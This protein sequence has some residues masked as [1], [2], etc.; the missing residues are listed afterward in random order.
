MLSVAVAIATYNRP[1]QLD[2][3]L[4]AWEQSNL[5]PDQ[6][7]VVDASADAA[8]RASAVAGALPGRFAA[9]R[10]AY[11]SAATPSTTAQRNQ[12]V[13]ALGTDLVV[14]A[15]DDTM[16]DPQ[17]LER[18]V[19]VFAADRRGRVGGVGGKTDRRGQGLKAWA[20][21]R[22]VRPLVRVVGQRYYA[23]RRVAFPEEAAPPPLPASIPV[24][25]MKLLNGCNMA[26]RTELVRAERF[27]ES[28]RGYAYGE[29][30]D[31]SFRI[32]RHHALLRRTDARV[33][34]AVRHGSS[35][36]PYLFFM[37]RWVNPA[38]MIGK[39]GLGEPAYRS[40]ARL[41]ALQRAT[42]LAAGRCPS[43]RNRGEVARRYEVAKGL[44]GELRA[45]T[46]GA[47]LGRRYEG[48]QDR[49]V[50]QAAG[51]AAR[52]VAAGA[53]PTGHQGGPT[54]R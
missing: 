12:A 33:T 54:G 27:D 34:M 46:P 38:Y 6:L 8:A 40:L 10:G 50:E 52:S 4:A 28:M 37:I 5:E 23:P 25:R 17:Y 30:F 48:I 43:A 42:D 47:E 31:L 51:V 32:G 44:V 36:D 22:V 18:L 26:F 7:V 9:G 15:D 20:G 24:V 13:D 21:A 39:L 2:R 49:I 41:M 35:V 16:P 19:E 29:D 53:E 45:A 3:A 11:L 1:D 14:F